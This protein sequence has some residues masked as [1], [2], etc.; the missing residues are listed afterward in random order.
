[1]QNWRILFLFALVLCQP[2]CRQ[3]EASTATPSQKLGKIEGEP[4]IV[5]SDFLKGLQNPWDLAF[6]QDQHMF[7]TEKCRGL[8]VLNPEGKITKLFGGSGFAVKAPDFF[9]QGQS[10]MN[11]VTLDP[12]FQNNRRIYLFMSSNLSDPRSNRVVRLVVN[13]S[14]TSVSERMDIVTDIPFQN[15]RTIWGGA[16]THS[17]GRLRFGPDGFLYITT[18][19]NHNGALP[20]DLTKL[21]GK[22]LRVTSD[23]SPAPGNNTP[24]GGD[25]RIFVY[26]IRNS[27]GISF[28]PSTGRPFI[29]EHGPFHSDEVTALSPGG[30]GGWDPKPEKGV[31]C[32]DNYCGYTSNKVSGAL[33]P[34]TDIEKFPEALRPLWVLS[35]S[36]GLG[37]A[38]FL[39]GSQWKGWDG[40]LLVAV[41]EGEKL[42]ALQVSD[43][44]QLLHEQIVAVPK[45][46][47]R[48]LVQDSDGNLYVALDNGTIW[49]IAPTP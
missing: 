11:G 16:G 29:A 45:E 42:Y 40:V 10:G 20:Q 12:N 35:D 41:M 8:S 17:G 24:S 5:R 25:P 30:N 19:D 15:K 7:F 28:K 44:D 48:S 36:Q 37:P 18:A 14:Y 38:L 4:Q 43:S 33:T 49:K 21:G 31:K 39:K 23:G 1:M 32:I 46:R 47:M 2:G 6:T 34:M 3:D 22:I 26:G 13:D 9:C 27:Q